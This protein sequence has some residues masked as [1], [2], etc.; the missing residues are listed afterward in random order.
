MNMNVNS[1]SEYNDLIKKISVKKGIIIAL[2][3]VAEIAVLL[4][5]TP[6]YIGFMGK[7]IIDYKGLHPVFTV[8]L[9]ILVYFVGIIACAIVLVPLTNS[10]NVECDPQ[11]YLALNFAHGKKSNRNAAGAL[12]SLYMGDYSNTL[13]YTGKMIASGKPKQI[14][15]GLFNKAR[16]EFLMGDSEALKLTVQQY[17]EA[18]SKDRRASE[19]IRNVYIERQKNLN[20][21]CALADKDIDKI[22]EYRVSVKPWI[23]VK[24]TEGYVNYIKGISAYCADDKEEC[25]YRLKAVTDNCEKTVFARLAAEYLEKLK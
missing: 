4:F 25:I 11:K 13:F 14:I 18:V 20:L 19:K 9:V 2:T 12:G 23:N 17:E 21:L 10:I 8:L 1:D 6:S 3:I 22:N 5:T 7:T 15:L 16:C 24:P